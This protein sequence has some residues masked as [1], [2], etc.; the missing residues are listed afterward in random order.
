MCQCNFTARIGNASATI[1]SDILLLLCQ[2]KFTVADGKLTKKELWTE[3]EL[4]DFK[5]N[6]GIKMVCLLDNPDVFMLYN[7]LPSEK[8]GSLLLQLSTTPGIWNELFGAMKVIL[9]SILGNTDLMQC[10]CIFSLL[11]I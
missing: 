11:I 1:V 2:K 5:G 4:V 9:K 3:E 8:I 7:S 6:Q 10:L